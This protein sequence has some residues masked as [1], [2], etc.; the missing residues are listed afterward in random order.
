MANNCCNPVI[1]PACSHSCDKLIDACCVVNGDNLP[2][3]NP[4]VVIAGS[5]IKGQY[6]IELAGVVEAPDYGAFAVTDA[7]GCIPEDTEIV[8]FLG[9]QIEVSKALTCT[10]T[11]NPITVSLINQ[12]QCDINKAFDEAICALDTGTVP[13]PSFTPMVFSG[14][15]APVWANFGVSRQVAEYSDVQNCTV[16]LRGV[17]KTTVSSGSAA[18]N[19]LV[20]TLPAGHIPASV[21]SFSV[22]VRLVDG[23]AST[24]FYPGFVTIAPDGTVYLD[25]INNIAGIFPWEVSFSFDSIFF[26]VSHL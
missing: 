4:P 9:T 3:I 18:V 21:R 16:K 5:G 20:T 6:Y 17:V 10:F 1:P 22:T 11:G 15:D 26:E 19:S 12:R 23:T 24:Q 8:G 2:C 7:S 14:G 25:F 13:C